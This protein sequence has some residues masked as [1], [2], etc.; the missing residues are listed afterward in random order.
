MLDDVDVLLAEQGTIWGLET[1]Q[2]CIQTSSDFLYCMLRLFK[3]RVLYY[4][5]RS[6]RAGRRSWLGTTAQAM[7]FSL[8]I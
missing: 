5:Y 7:T 3:D 1:L 4:E 6:E 8:M 2:V